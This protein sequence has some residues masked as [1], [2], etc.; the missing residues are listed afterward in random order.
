[1]PTLAELRSRDTTNLF[2]YGRASVDIEASIHVIR[3][4]ITTPEEENTFS[5]A[6]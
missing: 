1:M 6:L 2:H 4:Y 3:M 5:A